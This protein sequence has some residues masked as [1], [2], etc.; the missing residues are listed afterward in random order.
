MAQKVPNIPKEV[1][2]PGREF[3]RILA[4]LLLYRRQ[5]KTRK[6]TSSEKIMPFHQFA[7]GIKEEKK[8]DMM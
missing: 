4:F 7:Q 8:D 2:N 3:N 6:M 5:N 1:N